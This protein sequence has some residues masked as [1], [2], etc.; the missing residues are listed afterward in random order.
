M[1]T[2]NGSNFNLNLLGGQS[3]EAP[4]Q[5][6]AHSSAG[7]AAEL[8]RGGNGADGEFV[9][10]TEKK[11]VNGAM[12]AFVA[13]ALVAGGGVWWMYQRAGGPQAA[14][15]ADPSVSAARSS[16]QEFLS[17]GENSVE[18]MKSLLTDAEKIKSRFE[19]YSEDKKVPLDAVKTNPFW[20]ESLETE[21]DAE[22]VADM[23]QQQQAELARRE[24]ERLRKEQE[25]IAAA[26]AALQL[27]TLFYGTNPTCI[28]NGKICRTG[29]TIEGFVVEA[30]RPDAVEVRKGSSVFELRIRK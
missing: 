25:E 11:Q 19:S 24:A 21:A 26:A 14:E 8:A 18:E 5:S 22:A 9:I 28:I 23:G 1:S 16:I 27:E 20:H 12:V 2:E 13:L 4:T 17:G 7:F 10:P 29:Q 30:I 6:D 15:A 3:D